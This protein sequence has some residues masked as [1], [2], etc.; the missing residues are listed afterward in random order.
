MA[1]NTAKSLVSHL[2]GESAPVYIAATSLDV[3]EGH[4]DYYGP[5][6]SQELA[7]EALYN[8]EAEDVG[9]GFFETAND[10]TFYIQTATPPKITGDAQKF[11]LDFSFL[12]PE[13]DPHRAQHGREID[14][15]EHEREAKQERKDL[16]E[17]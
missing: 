10:V 12:E 14:R 13:M 15:Q 11:A 1:S 9:Q 4:Y 6:P 5:F 8:F 3:P 16:G 7:E 17:E 2:L